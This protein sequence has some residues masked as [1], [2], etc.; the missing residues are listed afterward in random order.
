MS[1][2]V[3]CINSSFQNLCT[4]IVYNGEVWIERKFRY[5]FK[6]EFMASGRVIFVHYA[7]CLNQLKPK[8][9]N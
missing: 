1:D 9:V 6:E 8:Y 5:W 3:D 2:M 4:F 7:D